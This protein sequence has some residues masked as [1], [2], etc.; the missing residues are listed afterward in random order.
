MCTA[1]FTC[2]H[3]CD[4]LQRTD[5][6]PLRLSRAFPASKK[7][8]KT[9]LALASSILDAFLVNA[10]AS[11]YMGLLYTESMQGFYLYSSLLL[12]F[13]YFS[14]EDQTPAIYTAIWLVKTKRAGLRSVRKVKSPWTLE[15]PM[16]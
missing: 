5:I 4:F 7:Y 13:N 3:C 6:A 1:A 9:S 16:L 11:L 2:L 10:N 15:S 12:I 14:G 8:K